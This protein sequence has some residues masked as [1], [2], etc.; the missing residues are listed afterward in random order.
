MEVGLYGK[1]PSHGDFLRRRT[2]DAF[3]DAWDHWLQECI[4]AS[5]A[6]LTE[7]WLEVYLTS[8]V[9][10][11]ACAGGVCGPD[12]V[13]GVMV[14]SVDRVGRYFPLTLVAT[15][16][17]DVG[18]MNVVAHGTTFFESAERLLVATLE[19]EQVDFEAFDTDVAALAETLQPFGRPP[20]VI[21]EAPSSAV[22]DKATDVPW[23]MPIAAAG[24]VGD[25]FGQLLSHRLSSLYQPFTIWWSDGSSDVQPTCLIGKGLPKPSTFAALLDGSWSHHACKPVP[26]RDSGLVALQ[27]PALPTSALRYRSAGATDVGRIRK[28]NQD[29]FLERSEVGLWVVADGLGG[30]SDGDIASRMVCDALADFDTSANFDQVIEHLRARIQE[31]NDHL[32]RTAARSLLADRTGT[33]IV[34]LL[35]RG[36][37]CAIVWAGDSRV[38]RLRGGRFLQLTEDH[39]ASPVAADGR[40]DTN[41]VTRAVGVAAALELDVR[42]DHVQPGDR[43]LLCSDGLTR[44]VSDFQIQAFLENKEISAAVQKLI[45]ASLDAGAPDNVTAVVVEALGN[46]EPPKPVAPGPPTL[47]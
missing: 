18:V 19:A 4:A 17:K 5:R 20:L 13:V 9:W 1:L 40:S 6:A 11:F 21:L 45:A 39:S 29:A 14:P 47:L 26:V 23:Q 32:L 24:E 31:V 27:V 46:S 34:V 37:R 36:D 35:V 33:T 28:L 30:H 8:P 12:G 7:R 25:A 3:V 42:W 41:I 38:Y 44:T 15:L 43:F 2:S 22:L 10:R 16:P